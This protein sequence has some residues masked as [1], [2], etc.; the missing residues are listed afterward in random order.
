ML[1]LLI[2]PAD[3]RDQHVPDSSILS[4]VSTLQ[5]LMYVAP[6]IADPGR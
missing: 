2:N 6:T 5:I 1:A 4:E 3:N